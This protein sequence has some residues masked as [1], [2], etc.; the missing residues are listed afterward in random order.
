MFVPLLAYSAT[1]TSLSPPCRAAQQVTDI[2]RNKLHH[3]SSQLADSF[4]RVKELEEE[5][6]GS[7]RELLL[8]RDDE[9]RHFELLM[10]VGQ[11]S[12]KYNGFFLWCYMAEGKV[13]KLSECLVTRERETIDA[14]SNAAVLELDLKAALKEYDFSIFFLSLEA[15]SCLEI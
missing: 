14:L 2:L 5:K 12:L 10:V 13:A 1:L 4:N 7:L 9:K 15:K 8:A 6:R 3:Q 11:F